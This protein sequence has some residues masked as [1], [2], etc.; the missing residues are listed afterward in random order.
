MC[1]GSIAKWSDYFLYVT[2]WDIIS[3]AKDVFMIVGNFLLLVPHAANIAESKSIF[4]NFL[5]GMGA[6]FSFAGI[7]QHIK[8]AKKF[9]ILIEALIN[10]VP[11]VVRFLIS[12]APVYLGFVIAGTAWF[13]HYSSYVCVCGICLRLV[14]AF[15][16]Y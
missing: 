14:V 1:K 2:G 4:T 16:F 8:H 9:Y 13:G 11:N 7:V 6:L 15:V 5:L 3:L 12:I 10:G